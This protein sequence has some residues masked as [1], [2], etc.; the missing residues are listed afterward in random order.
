MRVSVEFL[1]FPPSFITLSICIVAPRKAIGDKRVGG[2]PACGPEAAIKL[3]QL[4]K[5]FSNMKVFG[6]FTSTTDSG[7]WSIC[8]SCFS[9]RLETTIKESADA[10]C[11]GRER[12]APDSASAGT[13]PTPN[14]GSS[15]ASVFTQIARPLLKPKSLFYTLV[16]C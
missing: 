6:P 7:L 12:R 5:K 14:W 3:L 13:P 16:I 10:T 1:S 2:S 9:L 4:I 15:C 11:A 8:T